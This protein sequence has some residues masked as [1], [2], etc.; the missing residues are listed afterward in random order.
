MYSFLESCCNE[1]EENDDIPT[2]KPVLFTT[3]TTIPSL[4]DFLDVMDTTTPMIAVVNDANNDVYVTTEENLEENLAVDIS[5]L[6]S[7]YKKD[8]PF[9]CSF[10]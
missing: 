1:I 10:S 9:Q 4:T 3:T 8:N 2:E 7:A 5:G 6:E